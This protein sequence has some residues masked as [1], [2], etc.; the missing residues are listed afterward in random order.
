M[1]PHCSICGFAEFKIVG[2]PKVNHISKLFINKDYFVVQCLNCKG[3]YVTPYISFTADQWKQLYN[4]EYFSSQTKWLLKKREKELIERFDKVEE[5]LSKSSIYF[6]DIGTGE[7]NASIEALKR[8]WKVSSIDITDNRIEKSKNISIEFTEGYFIEHDFG[9]KEFDFIYLDSVL[10]HVLNPKEYL[11]KINKLLKK[12]GIV[13][14][15]VPNEDSLFNFIKKIVFFLIGRKDISTKIK[16]FDSPYHVIGFNEVSLKKALSLASLKIVRWQNIGRK[17]D[18]LSQ[19]PNQR[20]FWIGL[21][22]LLPVEFLGK[23]IK[24][25]VYFSVYAKKES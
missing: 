8:G 4:S 10:E 14:I 6:L 16:P 18:F 25:D 1:N 20:G 2:K 21:F 9:S 3:Y 22:F 17:F 23:L 5:Y 15:G 24:K 13:Y 19:S 11:L 7:G 12:D